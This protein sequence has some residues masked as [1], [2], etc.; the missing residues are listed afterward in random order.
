MMRDLINIINEA[1]N[2]E[3]PKRQG[4]I[5]ASWIAH[6]PSKRMD[7]KFWL[8]ITSAME[9]LGID[10]TTAEGPEIDQAVALVK[11][12]MASTYAKIA[13]L[14]ARAE[15]LR[16]KARDEEDTMPDVQFMKMDEESEKVGGVE[17]FR[18][19]HGIANFNINM[20]REMLESGY[21]KGQKHS[22]KVKDCYRLLGLDLNE[23]GS[24]DFQNDWDAGRGISITSAVMSRNKMHEIPDDKMEEPA[25]V[26]MID[27]DDL[28]KRCGLKMQKGHKPLNKSYPVLIDGNHRLGRMFLEGKESAVVWVVPYE[29]VLKFAFNRNMNP[30]LKQQKPK[31][32]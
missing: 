3:P 15:K 28:M 9:E 8:L 31:S 12:K 32:V 25:I 22:V 29:E 13:D 7:A 1:Q 30:V 4:V 19:L 26:A 23:F 20:A 5:K 27:S 11:E 2:K 18:W 17:W 6:M 21:C 16:T 10:P 24:Q 14:R